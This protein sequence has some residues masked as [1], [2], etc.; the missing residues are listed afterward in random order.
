MKSVSDLLTNIGAPVPERNLVNYALNGLP[1]TY[2]H[3]IPIIRYQK[4]FPMFLQMC[5]MLTL[6][7]RALLKE[8]NRVN[9]ATHQDTPSSPL[10]LTT[11]HYNRPPNSSPNATRGGSRNSRGGGRSGRGGLGKSGGGGGPMHDSQLSGWGGAIPR[12]IYYPVRCGILP[13]P[14]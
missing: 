4:P 14:N 10:V 9:Q 8:K 7:E 6:E 11:D 13:T 3:I 12:P 5:A 2:S 1:L